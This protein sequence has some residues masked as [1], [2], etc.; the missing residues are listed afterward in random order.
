MKLEQEIHRLLNNL[1]VSPR[2][3]E[4]RRDLIERL[5]ALRRMAEAAQELEQLR[6]DDPSNQDIPG[7]ERRLAD[8]DAG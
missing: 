1:T 8:K 3:S 2:D 6:R 4:S 5:I 7:L